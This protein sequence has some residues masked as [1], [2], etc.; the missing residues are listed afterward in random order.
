MTNSFSETENES[1]PEVKLFSTQFNM[2][3]VEPNSDLIVET[4][5]NSIQ[6]SDQEFD[7]SEQD[8]IGLETI[9]IDQNEN[10]SETQDFESK[11][12]FCFKCGKII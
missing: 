11:L 12:A 10:E 4:V 9:S 6:M 3:F 2:S 1:S 8:S 5:E 7:Q